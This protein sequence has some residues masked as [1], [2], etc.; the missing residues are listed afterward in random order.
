[1]EIARR[2][3]CAS[4]L[5]IPQSKSGLVE[6]PHERWPWTDLSSMDDHGELVGEGRDG[7]GEMEQGRDCLL[8]TVERREGVAWGKEWSSAPLLHSP[9][10]LL[11]CY[12]E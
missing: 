8:C 2:M 3:L 1:M 5:V 6:A 12:R 9:L 7:E 10:H 4:F 11:C